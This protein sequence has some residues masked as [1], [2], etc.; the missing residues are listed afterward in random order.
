MLT[1][2]D[3]N[4]VED[5]RYVVSKPH[6]LN[7]DTVSPIKDY[8]K[9]DIVVKSFESKVNSMYTALCLTQLS[10]SLRIR[11]VTPQD[12]GRYECQATTHP[13]QSIV[14]RL[15]IVGKT[16]FQNHTPQLT[17]NVAHVAWSQIVFTLQAACYKIQKKKI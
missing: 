7:T 16:F 13:P 5:K 4:Y 17:F 2:G 14:V 11:G 8:D 15:K 9:H 3:Q 10:W 6:V 1:I 12:A